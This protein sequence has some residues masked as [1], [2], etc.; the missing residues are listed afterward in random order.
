[1]SIKKLIYHALTTGFS[2]LWMFVAGQH[3]ATGVSVAPAADSIKLGS[4][5]KILFSVTSPAGYLWQWPEINE[6]I[7]DNVEIVSQTGIDTIRQRRSDLVLLRKEAS[8][9][10]FDTGFHAIPPFT[11]KYKSPDDTLWIEVESEPFLLHVA[12]PDVDLSLPIRDIKGPL[13]APVTF[14]EMLPWMLLIILIVAGVFL[15]RHYLKK[16]KASAALLPKPLKP[17]IP[18]HRKAL[19]A[20][21]QLRQKKLWQSGR[22]KEYH[23]EITGILRRYLE[24]RYQIM[25]VEMTTTEIME[26]V[27]MHPVPLQAKEKLLVIF[28]RA[29]LVKFAKSM[30]LPGQHEESFMLAIDF[31]RATMPLAI[32]SGS[33]TVQENQD[34]TKQKDENK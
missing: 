1:M 8:V 17:K 26:S 16:K 7:T 9:T 33:Q 10:S 14:R 29:D 24:E 28:E 27:A 31:V 22:V 15:Y 20:L 34:Q 25:A 13:R 6:K 19:D 4:Q 12:G 21:E 30:P 18:P 32:E 2:I 3:D 11:F 5:T 23:S